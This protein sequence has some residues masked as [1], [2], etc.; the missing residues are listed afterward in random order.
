MKPLS[1]L[2]LPVVFASALVAQKVPLPDGD[3][4]VQAFD[5]ADL[6]KL[7]G[8]EAASPAAPVARVADFLRAFSGAQLGGD[9]D[10]QAL[11]DRHVVALA[12]PVQLAAIERLVGTLRQD[13]T[14]QFALNA[15][16]YRLPEAVFERL[17]RPTLVAVDDKPGTARVA[18][19]DAKAAA[20]LLEAL[21]DEQVDRIEAPRVLAQT[22]QRA[23][24]STGDEIA[25]VRDFDLDVTQAALVADP[26]VDVVW[27]GLRIEAT[28][29]SV[30][31]G[32]IGVQLDVLD[33]QVDRPI[34]TVK[35]TLPGAPK[36]E[37]PLVVQVPV[38]RGF[39]GSQVAVVPDGGAAVMA[40]RRNG[41]SW[42]VVMSTVREVRV[43]KPR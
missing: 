4:V 32:G 22:L 37:V 28:M 43:A 11:G 8:V 29:A 36:T 10:L 24:L 15:N 25:Y 16:I 9:C 1:Q 12:A 18:V 6:A 33:Q 39:R 27:D 7:V 13:A 41:G 42:L 14:R 40:A 21:Q 26:I 31:D 38:I 30:A 23:R 17:L 2:V 3:R 5:V 19:I 20:T 35:T 34:H